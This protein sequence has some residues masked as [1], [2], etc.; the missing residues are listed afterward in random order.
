MASGTWRRIVWS[1]IA[2]GLL[3]S[4]IEWVGGN[5][6]GKAWLYSVGG[7]LELVGIV[8]VAF[9]ELR[10]LLE[11]ANLATWRHLHDAVAKLRTLVRA[12]KR[13]LGIPTAVV[14]HL[15]AAAGASAA[16]KLGIVVTRVTPPPDAAHA[17]KLAWVLNRVEMLLQQGDAH[18][19]EFDEMPARWEAHVREAID[20][21]RADLNLAVSEVRDEALLERRLGIVLLVVGVIVST[22]GNLA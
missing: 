15:G 9:P 22:C 3:G 2:T 19:K 6:S 4:F 20:G 14:V 17:E 13:R 8:L 1:L 11:E 16:G 10:P 12:V 18:R 21:I 5:G 7:A